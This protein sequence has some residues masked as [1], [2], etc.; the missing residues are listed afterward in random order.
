VQ[1]DESN[2]RETEY[3]TPHASTLV[4]YVG[5]WDIETRKFTNYNTPPTLSYNKFSMVKAKDNAL[6][7][8]V[9]MQRKRHLQV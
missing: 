6:C 7:L 3:G 4:Y 9:S 2:N 8:R 5:Q 1:S